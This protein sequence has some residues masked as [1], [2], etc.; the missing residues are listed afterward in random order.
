MFTLAGFDSNSDSEDLDT[1][2]QTQIH[3]QLSKTPGF[4]QTGSG[5]DSK[6][7]IYWALI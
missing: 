5:F 1:L 6:A 2:I 7:L 4:P 3:R